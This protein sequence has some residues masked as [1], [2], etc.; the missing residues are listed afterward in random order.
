MGGSTHVV[1]RDPDAPEGEEHAD[2]VQRVRRL[3]ER[4]PLDQRRPLPALL[5]PLPLTLLLLP[6]PPRPRQRQH[7]RPI[8][9]HHE[10]HHPHR[11]RE[12][13][14]PQ[15]RLRYRR[16]NHPPRRAATRDAR[17]GQH[18]P[19][20][21]KRRRISHSRTKHQPHPHALTHALRQ[22][23]LPV[24]HRATRREDA[25]QLQR[26]AEGEGGAQE[27]GVEGA[28]GEGGQPVDEQDLEGA[29]PGDGAGGEEREM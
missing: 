9:R 19:P 7:N 25:E 28:A 10:P 6:I 3:P 29:D 1:V 17:H 23:Q 13:H 21:E 15:Q 26:G 18:P 12:P 4:R 20:R 11:P 27:A 14:P 2:A 8:P 24:L 22:H 5:P 16:K